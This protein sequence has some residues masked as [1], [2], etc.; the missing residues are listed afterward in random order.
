MFGRPE[1]VTGSCHQKSEGPV[2]PFE[3]YVSDTIYRANPLERATIWIGC[4]CVV[5]IFLLSVADIVLR[6][7]SVEFFLAGEANGILMAWMIFLTLAIVT[8]TRSHMSLDF[9]ERLIPVW[10]STG[11][12]FF[13]YVVMLGYVAVLTWYC[14]QLTW[15]SYVNDVRSSSILRWPVIY[16]QMGVLIGLALMAVTQFLVLIGDLRSGGGGRPSRKVTLK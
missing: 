12:R 13:G 1:K 15:S 5:I 9:L 3:P 2:G 7:V 11:F 16:A 10:L 8:R 4:A 6:A 14:A